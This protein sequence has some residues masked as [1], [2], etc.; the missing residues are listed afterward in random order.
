MRA[1]SMLIRRTDVEPDGVEA[2]RLD[3]RIEH[4]KDNEDDGYGFQYAAKNQQHDVDA[5]HDDPA[6]RSPSVTSLMSAC[7]TCRIVRM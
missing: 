3:D 1:S 5:Q 6:F 2:E 7:G 4:R